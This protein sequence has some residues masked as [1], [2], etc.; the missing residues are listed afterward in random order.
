MLHPLEAKVDRE[1]SMTRLTVEH[2]N[3]AGLVVP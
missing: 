3:V 2:L 1:V